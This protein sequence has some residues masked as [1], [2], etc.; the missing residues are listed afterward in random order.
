MGNCNGNAGRKLVSIR[1]DSVLTGTNLPTFRMNLPLH[2]SRLEALKLTVE[3]GGGGK[4]LRNV[5]DFPHPR[6]Q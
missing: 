3:T 5:T 1:F 2:L 4:F 6:M